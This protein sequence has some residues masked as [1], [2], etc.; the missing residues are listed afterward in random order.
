MCTLT[1]KPCEAGFT[2]M[3]SRDED[4]TRGLMLPPHYRPDVEAIGP[5]DQKSGGTWLLTSKRGFTLNL[6]NGGFVKHERKATYRHSRGHVIAD[7]L[8]LGG[9]DAFLT[10]YNF[11]ELEPFTLVV[12]RHEP[13]ELHSIVWDGN[14]VWH[15]EHDAAM[16]RIW[17]S[18]TLYDEDAKA[19]RQAWY[20]EHLANLNRQ[21]VVPHEAH[22]PLHQ[23]LNF[24]YTGGSEAP[25]HLRIKMVREA[26]PQTIALVGVH[27]CQ[28]SWRM[29]YHDLLRDN[30]QRISLLD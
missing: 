1:Y 23:L 6:M 9:V 27:Y 25:A 18:S 7:F 28:K 12:I 20:E 29:Y 19:M 5:A 3:S 30:E 16:P 21:A 10:D 14:N 17:S 24:H 2:I 8:R 26:G 15:V 13:T 22:D 11:T 4:P